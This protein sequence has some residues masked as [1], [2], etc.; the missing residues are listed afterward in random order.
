M[1]RLK[2]RTAAIALSAILTAGGA[3]LATTAAQAAT[4]PSPAGY[5][6]PGAAQL[7][8]TACS[9]VTAEFYSAKIH[10]WV[11]TCGTGDFNPAP[12]DPYNTVHPITPNKIWFH[13][14][15][16]GTGWAKCY[17]LSQGNYLNVAPPYKNPLDL[18]ISLNTAAC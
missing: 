7:T 15:P 17:D 13:Q 12:Y 16:D 5:L 2:P 14:F 9:D 18:L 10:G 3:L 4:D 8:T 11:F 1:P 6:L